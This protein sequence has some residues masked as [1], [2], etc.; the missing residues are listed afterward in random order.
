MLIAYLAA[1]RACRPRRPPMFSTCELCPPLL[2]GAS[3]PFCRP[4]A[5]PGH[6]PY[7]LCHRSVAIRRYSEFKRDPPGAFR[8]FVGIRSGQLIKSKWSQGCVKVPV[9]VQ[10]RLKTPEIKVNQ[11]KSRLIIF[12]IEAL[13]SPSLGLAWAL[14][15]TPLRL[16]SSRSLFS[17]STF[18]L[19]SLIAP[20]VPK[21]VMVRFRV[22]GKICRG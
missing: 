3:P 9:K 12:S 22:D 10:S 19:L 21:W 4:P 7:H 17:I 1:Y 18:Q 20:S 5:R 14:L 15:G 8:S 11:G 6:A 16:M 13:H 2:Q